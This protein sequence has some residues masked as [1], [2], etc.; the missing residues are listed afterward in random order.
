MKKFVLVLLLSCVTT[1]LGAEPPA[2]SAPQG[3]ERKPA[4]PAGVRVYSNLEYSRPGGTPLLLDLYLPQRNEGR[5]PV[6]VWIHG[7]GWRAGN[8]EGCHAIGMAPRGYA[9]ASINYR[10]SQEAVFP[11]QIE[12][13]K[14]AIRYLRAEA[15]WYNLDRDHIGV[16]GASAGGHLAALVGAAGDARQL[17]GGGGNLKFSSRVQAVCDWFGPSDFS[18]FAAGT[19][20]ADGVVAQLLGGPVSEKSELAAMASPVTHVTKDDPPFLVMHGG[21]DNLVSL[22]QSRRL[23]DALKGAGVEVTLRVLPGAGHG[24]PAFSSPEIL[25]EVAVFFDRHLKGRP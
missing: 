9:V 2:A 14:A 15:D 25:E 17:D 18:Q 10:L 6:I 23:Y 12:D 20:A 13:C 5:L 19:G 16:W 21:K 7:G 3:G 4:L 1:F 8:K 24:G 22:E 11:A